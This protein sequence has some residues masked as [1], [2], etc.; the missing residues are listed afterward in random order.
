MAEI[1]KDA[2]SF[3]NSYGGY[4]LV[5]VR[6]KPREVIGFNGGFD[7]DDLNRKIKA[8]TK[9]EIE[10]HFAVHCVPS[11]SQKV[12]LLFMPR[13]LDS[14]SP[15][16]FL[17]NAPTR[18]DG[19][20]AY[21]GNDIYLRQGESCRPAEL[22][23]D[24]SFLCA[25][26]RREFSVLDKLILRSVLDNNLGPRDPG[27]V[28]FIGREE[29]LSELWH[30]LCDPFNPA[31][32]LAG[33]GGVGKTTIA[34]EFA[35]DIIRNPPIGFER[36][37]W[38]SAKRQFY[39]AILGKFVPTTRVDFSNVVSF[40]RSL[41]LELGSSEDMLDPDWTRGEI[42]DEVVNALCLL[43]SFIVIDDV[44]S[45]DPEQQSEVFHTVLQ[46]LGRTMGRPT[47]AS[48]CLLTARLELGAAPAQLR[49]VRGLRLEEFSDFV[50]MMAR[51]MGLE[52]S[53]RPDGKQ[54]KRFHQVTEGS[55]IFATS[56]LRLLGLGEVLEAALEKWRGSDG[57]EVRKFAFERELNRLT[58]S[59]IRTLYATCVLGETSFLE[60]QQ[61]T[62]SSETLLRDDL[63]ELR[64]YHLV[65]LGGEIPAGGARLVVPS[66]IRLMANLIKKRLRDPKRIETECAKARTGSPRLGLDIGLIVHRV[67][68]LWKDDS[69]REALDVAL[70]G[71]KKIRNN[72][73]LKCLLGRAYLRLSPPDARRADASFRAAHE[74]GCQRAELMSLWLD[75]KLE[76]RDWIGVIELTT[77]ASSASPSSEYVYLQAKAYMELGE[78][79]RVAGNLE[80][81]AKNYYAAGK[82]I[83]RAFSSKLV[84]GRVED[85]RLMKEEAFST[86][87]ALMSQLRATSDEQIEVWL[88]TW[89]AFR[90]FVRKPLLVKFGAE[91]LESW[92]RAVES[93]KHFNSR[94]AS[95]MELQLRRLNQALEVLLKQEDPDRPTCDQ[96]MLRA[97]ALEKRWKAYSDAINSLEK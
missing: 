54:M 22:S 88:A 7:C 27:F 74:L 77:L 29:Y 2:V 52:W 97:K 81:A 86:Y 87:V 80:T 93:R 66:G 94:S 59:Q 31:R 23:D 46:V 62:Q 34:R 39:T 90:C 67:I 82:E 37:I 24:F 70:M 26:G 84:Q 51:S 28:K 19:S 21:S 69:P 75:A 16:Q 18:Q 1:V 4:I 89:D 76:L 6:D 17:R 57:E 79:A 53:L 30:W 48:R 72:P 35:E 38:L 36:V 33:L 14:V 85:L 65:A 64:N 78:I 83:D 40:L 42:V 50:E 56:I 92:W 3:Y 47:M 20:R 68:A 8:A 25:Q 96:I 43:P 58:D 15:A 11:T 55:P 41:L 61:I 32:L 5:G 9:H 49:K 13:R 44:D 63:G 73:D 91:R 60:L 10:C 45:L 95:L 71:D 12:G